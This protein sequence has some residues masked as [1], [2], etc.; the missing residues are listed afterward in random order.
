MNRN[1]YVDRFIS[2][3]KFQLYIY[4]YEI[5]MISIYVQNIIYEKNTKL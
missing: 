3:R 5:N 1:K 2:M 4:F